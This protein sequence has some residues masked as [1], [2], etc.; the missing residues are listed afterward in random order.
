MMNR[1]HISA[2]MSML[3]CSRC[4]AGSYRSEALHISGAN[5]TWQCAKQAT[6]GMVCTM[7]SVLSSAPT[8]AGS[9]G[10]CRGAEVGQQGRG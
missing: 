10:S 2:R 7:Q 8:P 4:T 9:A 6:Q 3:L 1:G 5:R